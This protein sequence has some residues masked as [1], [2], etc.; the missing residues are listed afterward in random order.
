M[1]R[2]DFFGDGG[3]EYTISRVIR[4][5]FHTHASLMVGTR[6]RSTSTPARLVGDPQ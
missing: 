2:E 1:R 5:T 6:G 3:I 4:A